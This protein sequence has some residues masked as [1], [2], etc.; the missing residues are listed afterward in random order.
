[1]KNNDK[2]KDLSDIIKN[3]RR[4][5]LIGEYGNSLEKYQEAIIIIKQRQKKIKE[6]NENLKEIWKMTEYNI[7]SEMLQIKDILETCLQLHHCQFN[8]SKKQFEGN[9]FV[10]KNKKIMEKEIMEMY[11]KDKRIYD[12]IS[13]NSGSNINNITDN[14]NI[15]RSNKSNKIKNKSIKS[16]NIN[17]SIETKKNKTSKI[18]PWLNKKIYSNTKYN[19][20]YINTNINNNTENNINNFNNNSN[21]NSINNINIKKCK[22]LK[23][24]V[25]KKNV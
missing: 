12:K 2:I 6:G 11:N 3:A 20:P 1:M 16:T 10:T 22:S 8:Y 17:L 9:E 24:N 23:E 21:S 5:S 7:K 25:E 13:D 19:K 18:N 4:Y 14:R 15:N